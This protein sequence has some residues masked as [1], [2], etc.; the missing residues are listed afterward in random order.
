MEWRSVSCMMVN[1]WT[2]PP[3]DIWDFP[4]FPQYVAAFNEREGTAFTLEQLRA[5]HE[6]LTVKAWADLDIPFKPIDIATYT[7][8]EDGFKSIEDIL[9]LRER[10]ASGVWMPL[11]IYTGERYALFDGVRRIGIAK[12]GRIEILAAVLDPLNVLSQ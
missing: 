8:R 10:F 7:S 11:V 9:S 4:E 1:P 3:Q 2:V 6:S 12:I 5:C